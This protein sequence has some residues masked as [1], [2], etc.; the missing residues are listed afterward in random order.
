MT[1]EQIKITRYITTEITAAAIETVIQEILLA[2]FN[3]YEYQDTGETIT[4]CFET[5]ELKIVHE[6]FEKQYNDY[7]RLFLSMD[8]QKQSDVLNE[9]IGER[10]KRINQIYARDRP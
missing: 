7:K 10:N 3:S 6:Y 5:D 2:C 9:Y 4:A 1:E 8:R